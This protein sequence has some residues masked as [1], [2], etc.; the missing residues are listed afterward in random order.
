MTVLINGWENLIELRGINQAIV[1]SKLR[2][3]TSVPREERISR[4]VI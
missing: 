1:R 2:A 4:S 3:D